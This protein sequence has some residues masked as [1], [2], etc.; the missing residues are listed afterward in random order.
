MPPRTR[1]HG[2]NFAQPSNTPSAARRHPSDG[3]VAP[4]VSASSGPVYATAHSRTGAAGRRSLRWRREDGSTRLARHQSPYSAGR[5]HRPSRGGL[6]ESRATDRIRGR[7]IDNCA[8]GLGWSVRRTGAQVRRPAGRARPVD[9]DRHRARPSTTTSNR[10]PIA[11]AGLWRAAQG[12]SGDR[13]SE[14]GR[15]LPA[16][17]REGLETLCDRTTYTS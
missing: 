1:R 12:V 7:N 11:Q 2:R 8:A 5:R 13:A 4:H 14:M 10:S 17:T 6:C 3:A 15:A 9:R 16:R